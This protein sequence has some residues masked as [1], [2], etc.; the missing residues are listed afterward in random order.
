MLLIVGRGKI[1]GEHECLENINNQTTAT[2]ISQH[3]TAYQISK[4]DL[5]KL[6]L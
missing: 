4:L 1:F 5:Q 6:R 2:C 3:A